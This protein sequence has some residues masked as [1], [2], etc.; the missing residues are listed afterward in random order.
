ME[1]ELLVLRKGRKVATIA[2][3]GE[4]HVSQVKSA[5]REWPRLVSAIAY[6]EAQGYRIDTASCRSI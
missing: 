6:L 2:T 1:A 5:C 3:N 4:R